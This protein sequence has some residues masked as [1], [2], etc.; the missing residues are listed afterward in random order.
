M[1]IGL[2]ADGRTGVADQ[3][4]DVGLD[5]HE[6]RFEVDRVDLRGVDR[7][8]QLSGGISV[9]L[10][11]CSAPPELFEISRRGGG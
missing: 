3:L 1:Y 11:G 4:M 7:P 9:R 2:D 10:R 5:A 6:V 8:Q